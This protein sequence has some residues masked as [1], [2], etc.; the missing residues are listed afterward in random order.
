MA[1]TNAGGSG[2]NCLEKL[3]SYVKTQKGVILA[4]E[5]VSSRTRQLTW[6]F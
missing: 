6:N 2:A 1:D 4:S 3:K 5:I